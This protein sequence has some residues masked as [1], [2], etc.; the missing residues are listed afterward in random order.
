[1]FPCLNVYSGHFM[2]QRVVNMC[3]AIKHGRLWLWRNIWCSEYRYRANLHRSDSAVVRWCGAAPVKIY[4]LNRVCSRSVLINVM[5]RVR[6]L[7]TLFTTIWPRVMIRARA[8]KNLWIM[9]LAN[10]LDNPPADI[11]EWNL[12][13]RGKNNKG[14]RTQQ[15][16]M[17][18]DNFFAI[19]LIRCCSFHF[20][21]LGSLFSCSG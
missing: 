1:M 11:N 16:Y 14:R 15:L 2:L 12:R 19:S 10:W 3:C 7:S 4:W 9:R 20:F 21:Y 8:E 5:K 6:A 17:E 13:F 18:T